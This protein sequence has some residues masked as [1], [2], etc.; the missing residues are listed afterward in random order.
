MRVCVCVS[1][2][3]VDRMCTVRKSYCISWFS[4]VRE[5]SVNISH[6]T[7]L[8]SHM[9]TCRPPVIEIYS[10]IFPQAHGYDSGLESL[11]KRW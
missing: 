4:V 6:V 8:P 1:L 2:L 3:S 5:E 11:F 9:N 10:F 7:Q